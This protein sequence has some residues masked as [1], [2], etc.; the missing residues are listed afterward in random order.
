MTLNFGCLYLPRLPAWVLPEQTPA[1]ST[2]SNVLL[3]E[4]HRAH[5]AD[6]GMARVLAST[7]RTPGFTQLYAGER[8]HRGWQR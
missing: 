6:L 8:C 4:D 3:S 1:P 5:V 7:G 2:C